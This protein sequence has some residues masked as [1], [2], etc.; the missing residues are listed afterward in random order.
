MVFGL[1]VGWNERV[2]IDDTHD[3]A[4]VADRRLK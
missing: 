2:D 4:T 1:A 3:D